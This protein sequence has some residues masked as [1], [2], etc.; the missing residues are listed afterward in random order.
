M[1]YYKN[2]VFMLMVN[3]KP[4]VFH[5]HKDT[6]NCGDTEPQRFWGHEFDLLGSCDVFGHVTIRL[7]MWRFD[8]AYV[9]SYWW[10]IGT[11]RL[12][13]TVTEI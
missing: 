5:G 2:Q 4:S 7:G 6:W 1:F 3:Y 10:F 13:C 9:V 8:S 12:S 11:M